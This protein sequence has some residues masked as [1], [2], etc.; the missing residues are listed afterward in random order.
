M[1]GRRNH[2]SV[3]DCVS[4]LV[5]D[6][7]LTVIRNKGIS[8]RSFYGYSFSYS[9]VRI[10]TLLKTMINM[11]IPPNP[12][13]FIGKLLAHL[14]LHISTNESNSV[15]TVIYRGLAQGNSLNPTLLNRY[16]Y[17]WRSAAQNPSQIFLFA[18]VVYLHNRNLEMTT[19]AMQ[20]SVYKLNSFIN[21]PFLS[22]PPYKLKSVLFTLRPF[23]PITTRIPF[24]QG[25][26]FRLNSFEHLGITLD[27]KL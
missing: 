1:F 17:T 19:T 21:S 9:S 22:F 3:L 14:T 5:A 6:I 27:A 18:D 4:N 11:D 10:P 12:T 25:N 2:T 16:N 23:N 13:K 15:Q 8:K 24:S 20:E 26:F 7:Y